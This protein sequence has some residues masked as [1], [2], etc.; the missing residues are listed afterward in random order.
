MKHLGGRKLAQLAHLPNPFKGT[1]LVL[2]LPGPPNPAKA[3]EWTF[4]SDSVK[5]R[6]LTAALALLPEDRRI[7]YRKY[8]KD[9]ALPA[10]DPGA[11]WTGWLPMLDELKIVKPTY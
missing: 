3:W 7:K 5:V 1:N 2:E 10:W 9:H 11:I 8:L 4:F 6:G